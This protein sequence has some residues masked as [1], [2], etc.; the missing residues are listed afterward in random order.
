MAVKNAGTIYTAKVL[1][2]RF[3]NKELKKINKNN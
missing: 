3:K 2:I 1:L